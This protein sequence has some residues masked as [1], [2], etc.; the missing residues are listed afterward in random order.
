MGFSCRGVGGTCR[1]AWLGVVGVALGCASPGPPRAPSLNLPAPVTDL[2]ASRVGDDVTLRFTAPSRTTDKLSVR[3]GLVTGQFCREVE[4]QACVAVPSSKATVATTGAN[5]ARNT[6]TWTDRL[7]AAL[8]AGEPRLLGYR[9]E[10]FSASGRTAGWSAAAFTAAGAAPAKV[11]HLRVDG[12]RLGVV[13]E[14]QPEQVPGEV[15]I[16]RKSLKTET[17]TATTA[18]GTAKG[19]KTIG[20]S[21]PRA[22]SAPVVWMGTRQGQNQPD[23][24]LDTTAIPETPYTYRALR[25][26]RVALGGRQIE[27]RSEPTTPVEFMLR[28]VYPPAVPTGLTAAGY[29]EEASAHEGVPTKFA[30]DL[31]WEPVDEAGLIVPLAGY[32]V[33]RHELNAAGEVQG[34]GKKLNAAPVVLPA[35]HDATAGPAVAYRYSVTSVDVKGNE[36][37]AATVVLRPSS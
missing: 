30:V 3:S 21:S 31:I 26:V 5:G 10:F 20:S 35:F 25:Q 14:W 7:P 22:G 4:L 34:E 6:V 36:S 11:Q 1:I 24:V 17:A 19:P 13:V 37:A 12:S 28:D 15:L 33:Y 29:F 32:N 16:E 8:V 23:R 9:V 2:V 18:K 27:L